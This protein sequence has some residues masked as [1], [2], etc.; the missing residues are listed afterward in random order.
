M[1]LPRVAFCNDL[2]MTTSAERSGVYSYAYDAVNRLIRETD[3]G[4]AQVNL[5]RDGKDDVTAYSD[6]RSL[7]TTYVRNG[8]SEVIRQNSPDSG[9]TDTVRDARGLATQVTDG[10][11]VVTAMTYDNAGRMLTRTFAAAPAENLTYTYDDI[12]AGNKGRGVDLGNSKIWGH[13]T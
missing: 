13:N 8:F 3:Q 2:H 1:A 7:V 10:R 11:G 4:A 12:A 5:T 9:I 6:P